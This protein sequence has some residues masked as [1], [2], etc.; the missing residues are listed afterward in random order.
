MADLGR[1]RAL[2]VVTHE[3]ELFRHVI[4]RGWRLENGRLAPLPTMRPLPAER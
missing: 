4:D 2:L 1:D 3:P